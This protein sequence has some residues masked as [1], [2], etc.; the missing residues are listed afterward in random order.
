M[1][2]EQVDERTA[3]T[4]VSLGFKVTKAGVLDADDDLFDFTGLNLITL[5]Y[6]EVTTVMDGG[7][8]TVAL[9]EKA[10]SIAIMAAT[11]ITSDGVGTLY[12]VTGQ[13]DAI[14]N[15]GLAPTVAVAGATAEHD[16]ATDRSPVV[17]PFIVNGG[18]GGLVIESTET[19]DDTGEILWTVFYKPLEAGALVEAA[20]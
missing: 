2:D 9:N 15:G 13:P 19:G 17:S 11:T 8:S 7:A 6:G 10:S 5:M 14:A 4:R 18:S 3:I 16:S 20:A 12:L 1:A